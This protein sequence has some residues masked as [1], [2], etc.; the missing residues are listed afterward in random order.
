MQEGLKFIGLDLLDLDTDNPRLP[1]SVE[2]SPEAMLNHIALTT[3]IE[4]LMNAIAENGFF[5]GEPLVAIEENGRYKVVE[6]NRRLTAVKLIHNPYDCEKPS[7][8]MLTIAE[9]M[10]E[11]LDTLKLLPVIV[12]KSRAEILPYLGFRHITGVKQWEPLA[13]ARYIEQLFH[14][15]PLTLTT[16]ERYWRVAR[17]IGSRKDHIKRN[18]DALAVYK[19][20]EKN[21]F[22]GISGLD[23][24]SIKF[25]ILSTALAD[26]R[27]GLFVGTL[28]LDDEGDTVSNEVIISDAGINRENIQELTEWL[29]KKDDSGKTKVGESRNLRELGAIIDNQRALTA[30]RNGA[31]LKLAYQQTE[32]VRQDF[33]QLLFR[34]ESA[35]T[36]AAGM[37]ATIKYDSDALEVSRR[38]LANIKLIGTTIVAKKVEDDDGF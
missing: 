18:L 36:E 32:D 5:P 21:D 16:D 22:Y 14:L 4:D 38:L 23:E 34:A 20:L 11:K 33:M 13:K 7:S 15:T 10:A 27:I 8:R 1:E 3:S 25:S 24:E 37:V 30:F 17:A 19:I 28:S 2:R 6:G 12:R 26:E 9:R 35:I 29:Y 31:D